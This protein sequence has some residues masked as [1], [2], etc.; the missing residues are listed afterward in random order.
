VTDSDD[1]VLLEEIANYLH[2]QTTLI[3]AEC[4]RMRDEFR[5][6]FREALT[7]KQTRAL[8]R[9]RQHALA[10]AARAVHGD[11]LQ[12]ADWLPRAGGYLGPEPDKND[13]AAAE[14]RTEVPNLSSLGI[15]RMLWALSE[16]AKLVADSLGSSDPRTSP[17][18]RS[19]RNVRLS[20]V[21]GIFTAARSWPA[22]QGSTRRRRL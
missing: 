4:E 3:E 21:D 22:F 7:A 10:Q 1:A 6:E 20:A 13:A 18:K 15:A 2:V 12:D 11:D 9:H 14:W 19:H 5:V 16:Q 17:T 8:L